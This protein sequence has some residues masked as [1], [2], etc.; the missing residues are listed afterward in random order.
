MRDT[1]TLESPTDRRTGDFARIVYPIGVLG[2]LLLLVNGQFLL[3]VA[4][5]ALTIVVAMRLQE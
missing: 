2:A 5:I 4:A 1:P 3:F